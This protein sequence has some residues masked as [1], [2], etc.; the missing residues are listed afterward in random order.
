MEYV[1]S[2]GY[3]HRDMKP[4]NFLI[5]NGRRDNI[6]YIID[7]GLSK[8]YI[9]PRTK[10]HIAYRTSV[11]F[12]GTARY[13]SINAHLGVEQTRRDDLEGLIHILIYFLRGN[14]PWQG[15]PAKSKY[16]K[17]KKIMNSKIS[18]ADT[19]C[20]GFPKELYQLLKYCRLMKFEENPDYNY[21]RK[22]LKTMASDNKLKL[23]DEFDW[24][25]PKIERAAIKPSLPIGHDDKRINSKTV[26]IVKN[27]N[28]L[29]KKETDSKV[30]TPR[31]TTS[32]SSKGSAGKKYINE[33]VKDKKKKKRKACLLL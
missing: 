12:V 28:G 19:L 23:D 2:K 7:F 31:L 27:E 16:E 20:K 25:V 4:E 26:E 29:E 21:F 17:Y 15:L 13:T 3:I 22:C 33:N 8:R 14:L 11:G 32:N 10:C 24:L 5:G 6:V 30:S 18:T 1:H 9:D